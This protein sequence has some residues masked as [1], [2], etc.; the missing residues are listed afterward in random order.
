MIYR[1]VIK[2]I[3][4]IIFSI[5]FIVALFPV[6]LLV[7]VLIKISDGAPVLYSQIRCTK[8]GRHFKIYKF[9][10]MIKNA[11]EEKKPQLT[12][13]DDKRITKVGKIIRRLKIDEL[14][15]LINILKGDMSFV[16]PRPE[17]PE[18][19]EDILKELPEFSQRTKVKAGLTGLAQIKGS[20]YSTPAEKLKWDLEYIEKCT[21]LLDI[22]I[23]FNTI[24][25]I[26]EG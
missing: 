8:D 11:E 22:K 14:P 9:R 10:S 15:Q 5:F 24:P 7:S 26:L 1:K 25:A 13:K 12:R 3:L 16:G 2:R 6:F 4:D 19:M 23:I 18:L 17:R 21:I 20:Y